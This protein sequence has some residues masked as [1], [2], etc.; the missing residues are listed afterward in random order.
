MA[1]GSSIRAVSTGHG[2]ARTE[3]GTAHFSTGPRR[4][5][6]RYSSCEYRT[7]RRN[8]LVQPASVPGM[9]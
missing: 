6:A 1:P 2:V 8:R 3:R 4:Q 5:V 9:A 7:R